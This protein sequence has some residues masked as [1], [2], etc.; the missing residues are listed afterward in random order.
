MN[1]E[2][3]YQPRYGTMTIGIISVVI[4]FCI[5]WHLVMDIS[6]HSIDGTIIE[7]LYK[8]NGFAADSVKVYFANQ[9]GSQDVLEIN[10]DSNTYYNLNHSGSNLDRI[11]Q[12][13]KNYVGESVVVTYTKSPIGDVGFKHI[14]LG[15][16]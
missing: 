3:K 10:F 8:D 1:K 15:D 13:L 9:T 16:M 5:A 14:E 6:E 7:V 2:T 11:Y 12:L 4:I